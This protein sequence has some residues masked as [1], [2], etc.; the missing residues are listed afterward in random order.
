VTCNQCSKINQTKN[1]EC[2]QLGQPLI[3][4]KIFVA[5]DQRYLIIRR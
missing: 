4:E 3:N 5:G 2:L 1:Y